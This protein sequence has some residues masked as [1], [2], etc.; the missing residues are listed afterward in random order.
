MRE[1]DSLSG[2]SSKHFEDALIWFIGV[3]V[4]CYSY[5]GL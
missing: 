3:A 1:I 2:A 5:S 4:T